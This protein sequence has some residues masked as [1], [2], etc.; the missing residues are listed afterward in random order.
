MP[1]W[2]LY[3][4][5]SAPTLK[6]GHSAFPLP[7][8]PTQNPGDRAALRGAELSTKQASAD[9]PCEVRT[10]MMPLFTALT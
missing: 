8:S 5:S 4:R 1:I 7:S 3:F 6:Q 9:Y 10:H 2:P